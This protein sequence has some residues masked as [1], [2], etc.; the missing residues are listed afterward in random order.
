M[1]PFKVTFFIPFPSFVEVSTIEYQFKD[2]IEGINYIN[3]LQIRHWQIEE[4]NK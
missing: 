2:I 3:T 1:T 4:I